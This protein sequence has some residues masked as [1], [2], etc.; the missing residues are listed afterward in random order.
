MVDAANTIL[1]WR[2]GGPAMFAQEVLGAN[3]T[4]QQWELSRAIVDKRRVTIRSGHGTGKSASLCWSILWFMSCYYPCK[5]PCTAPTAHQLSD[6]LF[7]ELSKWLSAMKNNAPALAVEFEFTS[8][9]LYLKSNPLESFAVARTARPEQPEALQGFHSDNIL[10]IIDE[11]S[12]VSE[13]VFQVAEG[14]LSGAGAYVIMCA[15]PTRE[16]GYFY[17]SH[18]K[19]RSSWA[20]LHWDSSKS[21][22]VSQQYVDTMR[23]K[24]GEESPIFQVRVKGNFTSA[25][26]GV[27]PLH[28]CE[29]AIDREVAPI[30]T[31]PVIWGLDVA[32][33]G[34]DSTALAKRKGNILLEPTKEWFGL[35]TMQVCGMIATEYTNAFEKPQ[36]INVDT[37]G[38]GAGVFD[39]L[40]ELNYPVGSVNVAESAANNNK[41]MR[42]RDEMWWLGREWFDGLDVKIPN[43]P[44]LIAELT[45]AKYRIESSGKM[46]VESKQEMKAR[47][48]KS[49]NKADAFLQTFVRQPLYFDESKHDF[50]GDYNRSRWT[51]Y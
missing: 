41:Y 20:C 36:V 15:N 29:S 31:A 22:N 45:T 38:L 24:Y 8:G 47:G 42:L 33:Y 35:D 3:P 39:R 50:V 48:V 30:K 44:D 28:L 49:P 43:D 37:C 23:Q 7:A 46:K 14:A 2:Q 4:D 5:I 10:F 12:G 27:I 17:D 16:D 13:K 11:A 19:M 51:G 34:D 9:K 32:R 21:P 18:H 26:D 25:L 1:R 6:V 40:R